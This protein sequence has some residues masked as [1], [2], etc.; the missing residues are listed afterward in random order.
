MVRLAY[1][2]EHARIIDLNFFVGT[3]YPRKRALSLMYLLCT[4][5]KLEPM[6]DVSRP[7]SLAST[8]LTL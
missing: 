1:T 4:I 5:R 7:L 6:L 2:A 3:G 8:R